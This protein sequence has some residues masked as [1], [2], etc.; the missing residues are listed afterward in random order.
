M[1]VDRSLRIE[2]LCERLKEL[3]EGSLQNYLQLLSL[4]TGEAAEGAREAVGAKTSAHQW[5]I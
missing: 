1:P 3:K 2:E 5:M 4:L